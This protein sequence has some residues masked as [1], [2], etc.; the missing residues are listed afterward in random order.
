M[1]ETRLVK[2]RNPVFTGFTHTKA[3]LRTL[4]LLKM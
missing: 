3:I 2:E 1:I 4:K